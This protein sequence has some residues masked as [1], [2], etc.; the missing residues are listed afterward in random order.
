[1]RRTSAPRFAFSVLASAVAASL[2]FACA[3]EDP[4]ALR[5]KT[6]PNDPNG[7]DFSEKNGAPAVFSCDPNAVP[8]E[9]A[10]PRLSRAELQRTMQFAIRT[11]NA[12]D[13]AAIW[14]AV[15]PTFAHYPEDMI[16]PAPGDLRGGYRRVDQ[17]IQQTQIDAMYQTGLRIAQELTA[18][19][20]RRQA[21]LGACATNAATD[22]DRQCLETF[23][24]KWGARVLR[25]P[26]APDDVTFYANLAGTSPVSA[27]GLVEVVTALLN[28][29]EVLYVVEHGADDTKPVAPLTSFELASR[30][31]LQFWDAP[32]DDDLWH[33]AETNALADPAQYDAQVDRVLHSPASRDAL[34]EFV[35]QWLRLVEIPPLETLRDDPVFKAFAGDALPPATARDAM[36][37]DVVSSVFFAASSNKSVSDF[38]G[39]RHS[40]DKSGYVANLYGT[41]AWNG[42][43]PAP[44]AA[45]A[46]RAGLVTRVAF[47]TT[48]TP[49]TRPIHK[50]YLLRN[51][52]LCQQIGAPPTNV[53]I[54]PPTPNATETTR[55]AVTDKTATGDCA[56]CHSTRINPLGFV[57]EGFDALGRER[58]AEKVFD[59]QG[60]EVATL[61]ID[62]SA[63]PAI[64]FSDSRSMSSPS[65]LA[66]AIDQTGLFHSCLARQYF[67]FSARR[68]ES[69]DK[70][71]CA[72]S[73]LEEKARSGA[74]LVDVLKTIASTPQFKNRRFQ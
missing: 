69:P 15:A 47:L 1:M 57:L 37:D 17:S 39:D 70:D 34:A 49:T 14:D 60:K 8:D 26:L 63:V 38:F 23:L 33:A 48:G 29:P 2:A 61:P 27:A 5:D 53:N 28:A 67:R 7:G 21:M 35:S 55:Q 20:A 11:A 4:D 30:L 72:L 65:E 40:Y 19:D 3:S 56:G 58:T 71:G 25:R 51:A 24:G 68:I 50:G 66:T 41:Q 36:I 22:D 6:A 42:T 46:N 31:A 12:G 43:D 44:L 73:Q 54:T 9:L 18:T 64:T 74:P 32:P 16:A 13:A 10:L 45:S 62:T 59:A 52:I